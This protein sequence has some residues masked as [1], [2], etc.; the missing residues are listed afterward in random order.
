MRGYHPELRETLSFIDLNQ[1]SLSDLFTEV[2]RIENIIKKSDISDLYY[3][4]RREN[5]PMEIS[6]G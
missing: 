3:S 5:D 1:A 4:G 2:V 6:I